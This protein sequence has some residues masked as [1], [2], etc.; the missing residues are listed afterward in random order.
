M[1]LS[2]EVLSAE[3]HLYTCEAADMVIAPAVQG[4]I[5][6][7][8]QHTPMLTVLKPG[9]LRVKEAGGGEHA[10]YVSGG[11]LEIQPTQ[12]T[13]LADAADRADDLSEEAARA[14]MAAAE[15]KLSDQRSD[16]E[17]A[18]ARAELAEAAAR[19]KLIEKLRRSR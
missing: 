8:A 13:V 3:K 18:K 6:V 16:M 1:P 12:V 5:G 14:A 19:L 15:E 4:E 9:E 2:V 17:V 11:V 7:V 10:F